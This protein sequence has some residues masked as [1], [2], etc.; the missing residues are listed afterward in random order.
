M[1]IYLFLGMYFIGLV[2][3][4][5]SF[6]GFAKEKKMKLAALCFIVLIL[7]LLFGLGLI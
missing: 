6:I 3:T 5:Y 4:L 7:Y 2:S 1:I